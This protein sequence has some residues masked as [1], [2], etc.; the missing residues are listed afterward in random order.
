M[1]PVVEPLS[2]CGA[3]IHT[4]LRSVFPA[5]NSSFVNVTTD[6]IILRPYVDASSI[7]RVVEVGA[8]VGSGIGPP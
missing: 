2:V 3:M 4:F 5:T 1:V 8:S 6:T 7:R